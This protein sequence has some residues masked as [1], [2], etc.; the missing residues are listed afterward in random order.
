MW[1]SHA[2]HHSS[3]E[4]NLTTALRQN[5]INAVFGHFLY[6]PAALF[7][8]FRL[9]ASHMVFNLL[10]QYWIHTR[11]IGRLP[12]IIEFV[13][14][15]PSHHAVHHGRNPACIDKNFAGML[16]LFD[17]L[18][19]TFFDEAWMPVLK[20]AEDG[21][22]VVGPDG[23]PLR[24]EIVYGVIPPLQSISP[25]TANLIEWQDLWHRLRTTPRWV[26]RLKIP[27]ISPGWRYS[28]KESGLKWVPVGPIGHKYNPVRGYEPPSPGVFASTYAV[29]QLLLLAAVYFIPTIPWGTPLNGVIGA[30]LFAPSLHCVTSILECGRRALRWEA[31]RL[32]ASIAFIGYLHVARPAALAASLLATDQAHA[33]AV[34]ALLAS[35]CAVGLMA[36]TGG[37]PE[38]SSAGTAPAA[39]PPAVAAASPAGDA[40]SQKTA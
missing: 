38:R 24:E 26:D 25:I 10:Y 1:A 17:R 27:F 12:W 39:L 9:V 21:K 22:P 5:L 2:V 28:A 31:V 34:G 8:P 11:M 3:T 20:Q 15:T 14:N 4:Y 33:I 30:L 37:I 36:A 23:Q 13:F 32:V 35:L 18:Y 16:I 19:G 29:V 6:L 7:V 40:K